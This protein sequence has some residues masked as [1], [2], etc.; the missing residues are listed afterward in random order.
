M[1]SAHKTARIL[2][3]PVAVVRSDHLM[4]HP[5]AIARAEWLTLG[6]GDAVVE[7]F[8]ACAE[9]V[10]FA[11]NARGEY[12]LVSDTLV[13]RVGCTDRRQVLGRTAREV[14]PEP[15][16]G[17]FFE[18]DMRL[19]ASRV[20]LRNELEVHLDA[21]GR[22]VWCLTTKLPV[23]GPDGSCSGL[24]GLSRDLR[25][26]A[27]RGDE[28]RGMAKALKFAREH[29]DEDLRVDTLAELAGMSAYQFDRRLRA[30]FDLSTGQWVIRLR[31]D[32]AIGLLR[33]TDIPTVEVALRCGYSDQSAFTRQFRRSSGL[34]PAKFRKMSRQDA[35]RRKG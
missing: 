13:K 5:H 29:P 26:D 7:L 34:T 12:V 32:M 15:L 4:T 27:P 22:P 18:Q 23:I 2:Y 19:V 17:S 31:M 3:D 28:S 1:D 10:F 8:D 25:A 14:F 6:I 33:G 24:V 9:L 21:T 30:L 35:A 16:G 20:P 11:K